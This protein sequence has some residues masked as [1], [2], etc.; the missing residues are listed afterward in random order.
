MIGAIPFVFRL[1]A[2][3]NIV[4]RK[5]L[6]PPLEN[7]PQ[8]SPPIVTKLITAPQKEE[9]EQASK[10]LRSSALKNLPPIMP[11]FLIIGQEK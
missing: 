3:K 5:Y 4:D 1:G 7:I 10:F 2:R 8:V 11:P 6:L 9:I